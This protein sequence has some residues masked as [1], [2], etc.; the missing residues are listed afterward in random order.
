MGWDGLYIIRCMA[1]WRP[2]CGASETERTLK[3]IREEKGITSRFLDSISSQY[4][5][6]VER[7]VKTYSV[8]FLPQG[9]WLARAPSISGLT[10]RSWAFLTKTQRKHFCQLGSSVKTHSNCVWYVIYHGTYFW[11]ACDCCMA[12]HHDKPAPPP[13]LQRLHL[14]IKEGWY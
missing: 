9:D 5:L 4:G 10:S 14:L 8:L 6:A 12:A 13:P 11:G 2:V 3:T 1:L 7:D